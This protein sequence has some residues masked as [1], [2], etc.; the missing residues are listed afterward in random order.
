MAEVL[1]GLNPTDQ[2]VVDGAGRV[3]P[4]GKVR[5]L[6]AEEAN[7]SAPQSGGGRPSASF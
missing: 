7:A 3:R 6:D 2:V 5:L 1:T 4:K